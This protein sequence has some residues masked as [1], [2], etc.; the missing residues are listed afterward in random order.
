[1][2]RFAAL[3]IAGFL[4]LTLPLAAAPT[5]RS[6]TDSGT[7]LPAPR[8]DNGPL[9]LGPT[10]E[11]VP[12]PEK[13]LGYQLGHRFTPQDR[14]LKYLEALAEASPRVELREYGRSY[15]DRPLTL[16]AI[17]SEDN[18]RRLEILRKRQLILANDGDLSRAEIDDL[19]ASQP[20]F[21]WLAYGIHGNE[22]SST[23][24]AMATAYALAAASGEWEKLL[25]NVVVLIDPLVNPDG[26]ERYVQ[27]FVQRRGYR[28]DSS[29][30]AV[31]HEEPWPGGRFNHYLMDLN[32][33][34][35][36]V[37]QIETEARLAT[38]RRWEPHVYADFHEMGSESSY[39]FPPASEPI[40]PEIDARTV[41]WL[42]HFGR[43]NAAA[44]DRQGWLYY[45]AQNFD[46]FYPA[47][48]DSYPALRGAVGMT[49]E[50]AGGGMGGL[51]LRRK[52]GD[53]RSLSDRIG[54]HFTTGMTTVRLAA[55]RRVDLLRDFAHVR[56]RGFAENPQTFLWSSQVPEGKSL[57]DLLQLHGI[58]VGALAERTRLTA[59]SSL[60]EEARERSFEAGTY[61]V[62]TH[63]PLGGLAKTLLEREAEMPAEFIHAQRQRLERNLSTQFYDITSWSLPLAFGI[64]AWTLQGA[65]P[66]P[67]IPSGAA[68][69]DAGIRG[70][71]TLG[72]LVPPQGLAAFRLAARL[73][74]DGYGY[75]IALEEMKAEGATFPPGTMFIPASGNDPQL[76]RV[77]ETLS[78]ELG[79]KIH[80]LASGY[81][82]GKVSPGSDELVAIRSPRIGLLGGKGI[83]ATEHGALWFLFDRL[84]ELP[85]SR[86]D[87]ERLDDSM[88]DEFDVL[89]LPDGDGYDAVAETVTKSLESWV[90][91][92]GFLIA[93][94]GS[95]SWLRDLGLIELEEWQ[96][97][98]SSDGTPRP[99]L[100]GHLPT[101]G[102]ALAGLPSPGHALTIF[103]PEPTPV[104]AWGERIL[105]P[106]GD[107]RRDLLTVREDQ[108]VLSG[109][110][111]PEA[112]DRLAGSVLV[113]LEPKER[114][115]V[116]VFSNNPAFRLFWRTTMTTLLHAAMHGPSLAE[117][118]FLD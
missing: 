104:L 115:K 42:E 3:W 14:M 94:G 85:Y 64:E 89:V 22:S 67:V 110:V 15:E 12:S 31:E 60:G 75:R 65:V 116:M 108:P 54:R 53:S 43:A 83:S 70:D 117:A 93:I 4:V 95:I 59:T 72:Y 20:A 57:A 35:A 32:R 41:S 34:W 36:W 16:L 62:T 45:K 58:E 76:D 5:S 69:L 101:P 38:Y 74:T 49:F 6:A 25:E 52:S 19:V 90:H 78:H 40:L 66:A 10:D 81:L 1:M 24:A 91:K 47:Y 84:V 55:E 51:S 109:F 63:Q 2:P 18:L 46:L 17:S 29:R 100:S 106:S 107:P 44:F 82:A 37:T 114:G 68:D 92:G 96:P 97:D 102:A 21:V 71:G 50:V 39:F 48:G 105:L 28:P 8:N 30:I 23:E 27:G 87:L 80:R 26:R 113:G 7:Q 112:I 111:W 99:S 11:G 98:S 118:G 33:D 73:Q 61:V 77:L 86:L 13:I 9:P 103:S 79:L 56:R 88:L